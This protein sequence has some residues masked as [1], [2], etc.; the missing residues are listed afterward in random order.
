MQPGS[1]KNGE[2]R[3]VP[4]S[5]HIKIHPDKCIGAGH[6]VAQAPDAFSQNEDDGVVILLLETPGVDLHEAVRSAA[7]MC[8]TCAIE[9]VE[10]W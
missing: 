5:I 3:R 4:K 7:R 8:P 2:P 6:C 9:V 10:E 1:E